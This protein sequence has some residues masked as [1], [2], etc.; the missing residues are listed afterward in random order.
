MTYKTS[1][2]TFKG[3][4]ELADEVAYL[5]TKNDLRVSVRTSTGVFRKEHF[6]QIFGPAEGIERFERE[7]NHAKNRI[8]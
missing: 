3:S 5:A 7:M 2:Y 6:F 8:R 1:T 4:N